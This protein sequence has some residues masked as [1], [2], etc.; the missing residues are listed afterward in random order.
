ME[1]KISQIR[2]MAQDLDEAKNPN[3]KPLD[4]AQGKPILRPV[5]APQ[6][7]ERKLSEI[8]TQAQN[9][10]QIP[11]APPSSN[12][13]SPQEVLPIEP[14]FGGH[15]PSPSSK[16]ADRPAR[17]TAGVLREPPLNLPTAPGNGQ[18]S[19]T[20]KPPATVSGDIKP[21]AQ[22]P[23]EIL[24]FS[25]PGLPDAKF[26]KQTPTKEGPFIETPSIA[27]S[28]KKNLISKKFVLVTGLLSIILFA[29]AAGIYWKIFLQ[30]T[31]V[32]PN[33]PIPPPQ[34]IEQ[35]IPEALISY[36]ATEFI[37][38]DK[39]SYSSLKP[40]LDALENIPFPPEF[41]IY[42]P[43]KL[44]TGN[45]INYLTIQE[46]FTGLQIDAPEKLLAQINEEFNLFLYSQEE[47]AEKLCV[48]AAILDKQCYGPRIGLV[49]G[50]SD[51]DQTFSIMR[52]WE[53]TMVS[54]LR[55][56]MFYEPQEKPEGSFKAGKHKNLET[57]FINLPIPTMSIDWILSDNY[58]IIATSKE[59]AR[60]ASDRLK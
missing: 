27:P 40:K 18:A 1:G 47:G 2:T 16:L 59:A 4:T 57:N 31:P 45:K 8:L 48:D 55:P 33:I 44:K 13:G 39:I 25:A 24:G 9:R 22:T 19:L 51:P 58:L 10:M 32:E 34:I 21:K 26:P 20:P 38:I 12:P 11:Y 50:I 14:A 53:K 46:F 5:A 28:P 6:R 60:L 29:I 17:D 3:A 52:G 56:I 54:D 37:E 23:E 7:D 42:T 30:K 35:P 36:G 43:I 49:V 15:A 41:L